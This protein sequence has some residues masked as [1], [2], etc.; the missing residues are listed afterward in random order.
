MQMSFKARG[1]GDGARARWS[2]DGRGDESAS[3]SVAREF[4]RRVHVAGKVAER[5]RAEKVQTVELALAQAEHETNALRD[6]SIDNFA[7]EEQRVTSDGTSGSAIWLTTCAVCEGASASDCRKLLE[8]CV[9]FQSDLNRVGNRTNHGK[10]ISPLA[11]LCMMLELSVVSPAQRRRL[12]DLEFM[13]AAD[14]SESDGGIKI[15][16]ELYSQKVAEI[17]KMVL[18]C[19][20]EVKQSAE[21]IVEFATALLAAGAD[22]NGMFE[23]KPETSLVAD[24]RVAPYEGMPGTKGSPLFFCALA[25]ISGAGDEALTLAAR[26]ISKGAEANVD[27][28]RPGINACC[29]KFLNPLTV[30]CAA[31]EASIGYEFDNERKSRIARLGCLIVQCCADVKLNVESTFTHRLT[32]EELAVRRIAPFECQTSLRGP[33]IFILACAIAEG[34][35]AS[36]VALMDVIM[37]RSGKFRVNEVIVGARPHHGLVLPLLT[38][39]LDAIDAPASFNATGFMSTKDWWESAALKASVSDMGSMLGSQMSKLEGSMSGLDRVTKEDVDSV[40]SFLPEIN[41]AAFDGAGATARREEAETKKAKKTYVKSPSEIAQEENHDAKARE[42]AQA[43][44][45]AERAKY[46]EKEQ[47]AIESDEGVDNE[48]TL[49]AKG[50]TMYEDEDGNTFVVGYTDEALK[51]NSGVFQDESRMTPEEL[52]LARA[53]AQTERKENGRRLIEACKRATFEIIERGEELIDVASKKLGI[54]SAEDIEVLF[55][56]PRQAQ[57][58]CIDLAKRLLK[59]GIN[60]KVKMTLTREYVHTC[61]EMTATPLSIVCGYI[62]RGIPEM[63]PL[64]EALVKAGADV[65]TRGLGPYPISAPPIFALALALYHGVEGAADALEGFLKNYNVVVDIKAIFPDGSKSTTLIQLIHALRVGRASRERVQLLIELLLEK[66][67]DPNLCC[68]EVF[69]EHIPEA[70]MEAMKLSNYQTPPVTFFKL[71]ETNLLSARS[72]EN[73]Q[74]ASVVHRLRQPSMDLA[75]LNP[76]VHEDLS[77][78]ELRSLEFGKIFDEVKKLKDIQRAGS[79]AD[80]ESVRSSMFGSMKNFDFGAPFPALPD[81]SGECE[82]PP[83]FWAI[84]AAAK[85]GHVEALKVVRLLISLGADVTYM[86][87]KNYHSWAE[88]S[89]VAL[90]VM[91]ALEAATPFSPPEEEEDH[92]RISVGEVLLRLNQAA[93]PA[94]GNDDALDNVAEHTL[95]QRGLNEELV[96]GKERGTLKSKIEEQE[97]A[98]NPDIVRRAAVLNSL[99]LERPNDRRE[100]KVTDVHYK[101]VDESSQDRSENEN[102][103]KLV[104]GVLRPEH[105]RFGPRHLAARR[106]IPGLTRTV[107]VAHTSIESR[108]IEL[109]RAQN[110]QRT[111]EIRRAAVNNTTKHLPIATPVATSV[112]S[113][114]Q[115]IYATKSD[116]MSDEYVAVDRKEEEFA[117]AEVEEAMRRERE[118][119][120][121]RGQIVPLRAVENANKVKRITRREQTIHDDSVRSSELA[122]QAHWPSDDEFGTDTGAPGPTDMDKLYEEVEA[123][124]PPSQHG[125]QEACGEADNREVVQWDSAPRLSREE[126]EL[127]HNSRAKTTLAV[128]VEL[129]ERC[130]T[131][132]I[133]AF[134][135][136]PLLE[137]FGVGL[138]PYEYTPLF[139]ALYGAATSKSQEQ[140]TVGV[141]LAKMCINKGANVNKIGLHSILAPGA[142]MNVSE[143]VKAHRVARF[144][145][146]RKRYDGGDLSVMQERLD[147]GLVINPETSIKI[148]SYPLMWAVTTAIRAESRKLGCERIVQ[149]MLM[150]GADPTSI[151][152]DSVDVRTGAD[153]RLRHGSVLYLW[154]TDVDLWKM[155]QSAYQSTMSVRLNIARMLSE[156]GARSTYRAKSCMPY[157]SSHLE[158]AASGKWLVKGKDGY[159]IVAAPDKSET[160]PLDNIESFKV[161]VAR[162]LHS[163]GAQKRHVTIESELDQKVGALRNQGA[164]DAIGT[165]LWPDAD[166]SMTE[167]TPTGSDNITYRLSSESPYVHVQRQ[168]QIEIV[169]LSDAEDEEASTVP[170]YDKL[171][172]MTIA[173]A[174]TLEEERTAKHAL[175]KRQAAVVR[176]TFAGTLDDTT[177]TTI[178]ETLLPH[179]LLH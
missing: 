77:D 59:N 156:C 151:S 79:E 176:A 20:D 60:P 110:E 40:E 52:E 43:I 42:I 25:V 118:K 7:L 30:C 82:Y 34:V 63:I 103:Y 139:I 114:D 28:E 99:V 102:T 72:E 88:G 93:E 129:L 115:N 46:Q 105:S 31:L 144:K 112:T 116:S 149:H 27:C 76:D 24:R 137:I 90:A 12:D 47:I 67:A 71:P 35:G 174:K 29:G 166:E 49:N 9:K 122:Q 145:E 161:R 78:G 85:E 48:E 41:D 167:K 61:P 179:K 6:G 53:K 56:R 2:E 125:D 119:M 148:R 177:K 132:H 143:Q 70:Y 91:S 117:M 32:V 111:N 133:D 173:E 121:L 127:R 89:L 58:D 50:A 86:I 146:L 38:M 131:E 51:S 94:E 22:P 140:L 100:Y 66:G 69:S 134:G 33:A 75:L 74:A 150:E 92:N 81:R 170:S 57:L 23:A 14:R 64:M 80:T 4:A 17:R 15:E 11:L 104:Q 169:N 87:E 68:I 126:L 141:T 130:G 106:G 98:T 101:N 138:I 155:S 163:D 147:D 95:L 3:D 175:R 153:A 26:L 172:A 84:E 162:A 136:N 13:R 18:E 1:D 154:G 54:D 124:G 165:W 168:G 73:A 8:G 65:S 19:D 45:E 21:A 97:T 164:S 135:R 113:S 5:V 39:V 171:E 178:D 10:G 107:A 123:I 16:G 36:A 108:A 142:R 160:Q 120:M 37:E 152:L 55:N 109:T 96:K 62:A 157:V 158:A 128:A 44:A 83:L 159:G